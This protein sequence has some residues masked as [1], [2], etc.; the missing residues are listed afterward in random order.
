METNNLILL[1]IGLAVGVM[2]YVAQ[3]V[4]ARRERLLA[5][6]A[7]ARRDAADEPAPFS[8]APASGF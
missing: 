8:L 7:N 5:A 4:L 1:V 2:N 6:G 3:V